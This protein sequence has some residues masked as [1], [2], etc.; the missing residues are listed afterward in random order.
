VSENG[1][2]KWQL[3]FFIVTGFTVLLG[4]AVVANDRVRASEDQR[5]EMKMDNC[6][7]E[8]TKVNQDILLALSDIK[9]DVKVIRAEMKK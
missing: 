2:G 7:R 5:V 6:N 4:G 3:A 8:Q 9:S 1:N